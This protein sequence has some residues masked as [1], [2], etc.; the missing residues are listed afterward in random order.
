VAEDLVVDGRVARLRVVLELIA[1]GG[2]A[3]PLPEVGDE[4]D[5][6]VELRRIARDAF[7]PAQVTVKEVAVEDGDEVVVLIVTEGSQTI[8]T[9][10]LLAALREL[11]QGMPG[12]ICRHVDD[13]PAPLTARAA[14]TR[15]E[16]AS[17]VLQASVQEDEDEEGGEHSWPVRSIRAYATEVLL[18]LVVALSI[19]VLIIVL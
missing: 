13:L 5:L 15:V 18:A 19:V 3:V 17:G 7:H 9:G 1:A 8:K 14:D 4:E 2:P 12:V 10:A 6:R 16:L 11:K